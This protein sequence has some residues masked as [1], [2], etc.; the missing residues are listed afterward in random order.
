MPGAGRCADAAV[1]ARAALIKV[2]LAFEHGV[3]PANLHYAAPNPNSASLNAGVL[4]VPPGACCC[5]AS[6]VFLE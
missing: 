3:L 2:C 5:C 4:K 6:Q 1:H